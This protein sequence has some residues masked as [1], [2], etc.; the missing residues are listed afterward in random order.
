M[1]HNSA[2]KT[3]AENWAKRGILNICQFEQY[4]RMYLVQATWPGDWVVLSCFKI[5]FMS[6]LVFGAS[7]N[8]LVQ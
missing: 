2:L 5:L 8:V 4:F 3:F 6:Y 7:D 1:W